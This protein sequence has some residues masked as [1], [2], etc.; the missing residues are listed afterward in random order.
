MA[1]KKNNNAAQAF[2]TTFVTVNLTSDQK[3]RIAP[4]RAKNQPQIDDLIVEVLQSGHKLTFSY[5]EHN[6]SFICS[7]T[8][9]REEC[10]NKGLC[11]TSHAKDYS[12]ALWV[13]LYKYHE[14]FQRGAW[15]NI[16]DEEDFG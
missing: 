11:M 8:G 14:T 16:A 9:S 12:T 10:I 3:K 13:A 5:S 15:E 6:D 1:R 7:L 4:W 2:S